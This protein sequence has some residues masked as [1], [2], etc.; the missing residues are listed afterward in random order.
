MNIDGIRWVKP[1]GLEF[2]GF[3]ENNAER[4]K[5]I[6]HNQNREEQFLFPKM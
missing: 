1:P 4:K 3:P 6:N 2:L 5:K